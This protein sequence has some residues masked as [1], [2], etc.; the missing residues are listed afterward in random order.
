ML[1]RHCLRT[2]SSTQG[3]IA[4]SSAEAEFYAMIDGVLRGKGVLNLAL[5][6]GVR[7]SVVI[8][9]FTDRAAAKSFVAK[10]GLG[11]MRHLQL[12]DLWLQQQVGDGQVVV[13]KVPGVGNPADLMTKFL[14][15]QDI[16]ERLRCL[17]LFLSWAEELCI[18]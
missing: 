3:A 6:V 12:R 18:V 14:G 16:I 7:V 9:L 11:G 2:W 17:H 5:E 13:E 8:R 1:G 15:R 10:R 4:L